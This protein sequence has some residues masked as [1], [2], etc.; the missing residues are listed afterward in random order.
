[1]SREFSAS[2]FLFEP[3]PLSAAARATGCRIPTPNARPIPT[4]Q[5]I[6]RIDAGCLFKVKFDFQSFIPPE[7]ICHR[8]A[9]FAEAIFS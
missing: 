3:I 2:I 8:E 1:L 6:R 5:P 7:T 9:L 4:R